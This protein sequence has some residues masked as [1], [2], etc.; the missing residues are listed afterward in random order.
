M[1]DSRKKP[2]TNYNNTYNPDNVTGMQSRNHSLASL[3]Q[4]SM[5]GGG[6]GGGGGT[7]IS[8]AGGYGGGGTGGGCGVGGTPI[9]QRRQYEQ[10]L[11]FHRHPYEMSSLQW[12][13]NHGGHHPLA[14][15][16]TSTCQRGPRHPLDSR[17]WQQTRPLPD[18]NLADLT[19]RTPGTQLELP[20]LNHY[21]YEDVGYHSSPYNMCGTVGPAAMRNNEYNAYGIRPG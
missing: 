5:P 16:G 8:M 20:L 21:M 1:F 18:P 13:A 7:P 3:S 10:E 11:A 4:F 2:N 14:A 12:P 17:T 19:C 6:Y 9:S 15:C